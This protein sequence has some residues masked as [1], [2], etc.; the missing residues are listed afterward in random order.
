M[1]KQILNKTLLAVSICAATTQVNALTTRI[2]GGTE[3]QSGSY[4]WMV[5]LQGRGQ[6]FCGASMVARDWVL[7]AAHCVEG[8]SASGVQAVIGEFD[9]NSQNDGGQQRA[10]S[11]IIIHPK[12]QSSSNDHDIALLQL[13]TPVTGSPVLAATS[14]VMKNVTPGKLLT[15]MGWGNQ[16]TSGEQFP[17]KLF[18][19]QVPY[20]SN[21]NCG[22]YSA[23]EITENMLCAGFPKG[24]KDSCQGDSGGP[25][26]Y[27]LDGQWQQVGV[28]SFGEGCAQPDYPGVYARVE[29]YTDWIDGYL[30]GQGGGTDTGN[31][32]DTG[33]TDTGNGDD[34]GGTGDSGDDNDMG[35]DD[36]WS[37]DGYGVD[38]QSPEIFNLPDY[39]DIFSL[40]G[41]SEEVVVLLENMTKEAVNIT[42]ITSDS[43]QFK[44]AGNTC[45]TLKPG[46]TCVVSV[47]YTPAGNQDYAFGTMSIALDN[48]ESVAIELYGEDLSAFE[49]DFNWDDGFD[50]FSDDDYWYA[51]DD[52]MGLFGNSIR[53][54]GRA[55][56]SAQVEGPGVLEFDLLM[57]DEAAENS[58]TY[59]V[60]GKPVR[61][62]TGAQ[63][64][65]V[66]HR[67][68]LSA[69][70]HQ[71]SWIYNKRK[72]TSGQVKV[73]NMKFTKATGTTASA[74]NG[75][76]GSSDLGFLA[77]LLLVVGGA[78]KWLAR[79]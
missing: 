67:T 60:D 24:G 36:G 61:S 1:N 44:V 23:G 41:K 17:N 68:E 42:G 5:S 2:I 48:G 40:E 25:L 19:V 43:E 16:S 30:S 50:W 65:T 28:V 56:M 7:T 6:H 8:E 79:K 73:S 53:T 59:L 70:R 29:K 71:I 4:P 64:K 49:D 34:T 55:V 13:K 58:I 46:A 69:G 78:R 47:T 20:V 51:R 14:T 32:D 39:I 63:K 15:V 45:Q 66:N 76:G 52:Q 10:I 74:D 26:L 37:D 31:G 27:Q 38:S 57:P 11:R 3:A 72:E 77:A 18:E 33:G 12:R 9:L 35:T 75:G 62:V 22:N 21:D 54:G